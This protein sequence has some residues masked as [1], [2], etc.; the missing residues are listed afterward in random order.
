[1]RFLHAGAQQN[2]KHLHN[3]YKNVAPTLKTLGLDQEEHDSLNVLVS[4][5]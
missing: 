1:M 2:T 4:S 5:T 3:I